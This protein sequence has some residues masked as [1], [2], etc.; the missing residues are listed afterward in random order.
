M[1]ARDWGIDW[2][3]Q[4]GRQRT[5][6]IDLQKLKWLFVY[7]PSKSSNKCKYNIY[8]TKPFSHALANLIYWPWE[9]KNGG[10]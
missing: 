2:L 10:Y 6:R 5:E 7:I 8:V 9:V 3:F 4:V 1:S